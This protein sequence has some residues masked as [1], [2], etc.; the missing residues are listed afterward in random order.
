MRRMRRYPSLWMGT[1]ALMAGISAWGHDGSVPVSAPAPNDEPLGESVPRIQVALLLDTSNSMDGLINQAKTQLW[2]FVNEFLT[3]ERDG[4]RPELQVALFEYGNDRLPAEGGFIRQVLPLTTDL[5]RVSEELFALR[6]YG[7]HEYC[8]QVIAEAVEGLAW[9]ESPKDLKVIFIA[10]NEPF[11]QGPVDYRES[12]RAAIAKGIV[13]N[14]IHCGSH[15]QGVAGEWD[16]GAVLAEGTYM[17][18]DQNAVAVHIEAPQDAEIA[19]LGEELNETYI[20]FGAQG[21]AG[22]ENQAT[23]D[24]NAE[25][26]SVG[27]AVQRAISKA[28]G[29]YRNAIWDLVDAFKEQAVDLEDV[30][31]E[32]LPEPMRKMNVEQRRAYVEDNLR[33][34]AH[35]QEHIQQLNAQRR[36]HVARK[37]REQAD[38]SASDTLD[39]AM[40]EAAQVQAAEKG[41]AFE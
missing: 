33:R 29:F 35:I 19:R 18:I 7:G 16:D 37:L 8:G 39:A 6:T 3:A 4:E 24:D 5:D 36:E 26:A 14:T 22:L 20:P 27:G 11:T 25:S 28:S 10:G 31:T 13:V 38:A 2:K 30:K 15:E 41:F 23:Q 17:T 9:S 40:I 12:C 21:E 32:D 1:I 34:R